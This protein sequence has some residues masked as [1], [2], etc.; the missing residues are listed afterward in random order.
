MLSRRFG[1]FFDKPTVH[2]MRN[3]L[4]ISWLQDLHQHQDY[5]GQVCHQEPLFESNPA[6]TA[7]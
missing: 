5:N 7:L 1:I 4:V 3:L 2:L 6:R